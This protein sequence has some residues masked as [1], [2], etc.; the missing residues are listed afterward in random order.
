MLPYFE[1]TSLFGLLSQDLERLLALLVFWW[2]NTV[3]GKA[4]HFS[5]TPSTS[6][7][8]Q[9]VWILEQFCDMSW[10]SYNWTQFWHCLRGVIESPRLKVQSQ[11]IALLQTPIASPG[12]HLCYWLTHYNQRSLGSPTLVHEFARVA[13]RTHENRLF[14]S[15][16]MYYRRVRFRNS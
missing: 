7:L 1:W 2:A 6:L 10:V 3:C 13:H 14:S 16:P 11:K 9:N 4:F 15:L 8:K 5:P 12:C